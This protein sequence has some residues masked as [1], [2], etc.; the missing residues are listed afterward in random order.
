MRNIFFVC[1]TYYQLIVSLQLKNSIFGADDCYLILS[2]HSRNSE[3][4]YKK[5]KNA[6]IFKDVFIYNNKSIDL[7][8]Y[9]LIQSIRYI[10]YAVF[11]RILEINNIPQNKADM[12]FFY[13][14]NRSINMLYAYL[15]KNKDIAVA[16]FEEGMLS[17]NIDIHRENY[18]GACKKL[19][20]VYFL[21]RKIKKPLIFD[22]LKYFYCFNPLI[23]NGDLTPVQIPRIEPNG[24]T[25]KEIYHIFIDDV[26]L[27]K[28][29]QKY[30]F[31]TS[32]FDFEGGKPVG[33]YELVC[34]IADLVGK[35]NLLVKTH[36]RDTRTIYM[37]NGFNVD[38][39]SSIPWEAIQLSGDF[40]D[41]IFMTINSG[42]VLSGSTMSDKPV[43]TYFMY[44]LCD[45]SGN[46]LSQKSARDI[47]S[48]L[49]NKEMK[50]VLRT[51]KIVERLND[52]L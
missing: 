46:E 8:E 33:E 31:F 34:K 28:Y 22:E 16:R 35:D 5:I 44:K 52:I 9:N 40:S 37:D 3:A 45:L 42:S 15:S 1:N 23:Y 11:G 43:R 13:N 17:Y 48:L 36:P 24:K 30:I 41:K 38:K 27:T 39:N 49:E 14:V 10:L 7:G 51:V 47:E 19:K 20:M 2:D 25:V 32:V 6:R 21:R 50:E 18:S 4:I 29:E 26:T 12:I